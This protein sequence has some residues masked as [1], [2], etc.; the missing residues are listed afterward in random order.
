MILDAAGN[1]YGTTLRGDTYGACCGT[2]FELSPPSSS[3]GTWTAPA[4]FTVRPEREV[5]LVKGASG[6]GSSGVE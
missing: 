2:A 4:I 5:T 6:R 1:L 3:G